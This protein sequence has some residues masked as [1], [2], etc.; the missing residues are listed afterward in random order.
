[1]RKNGI[2]MRVGAA[3]LAASLVMVDAVPTLAAGVVNDVSVEQSVVGA[4]NGVSKVIGLEGRVSNS[5]LTTMSSDDGNVEKDYVW[6]NK[7][8]SSVI[9]SG[10]K[11]TLLDAATGLYKVGDAY[12]TSAYNYSETL[13]MLSGKVAYVGTVSPSEDATTGLVVVNGKYYDGYSTQTNTSG[14]ILR[15]KSCSCLKGL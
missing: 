2:T 13:C 15:W 14:D 1:M 5:Y 9:V 11:D 10:Q 12:Y 4:V 6:V 8:S 3:I 7:G